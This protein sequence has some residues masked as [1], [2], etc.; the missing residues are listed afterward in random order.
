ML[1]LFVRAIPLTLLKKTTQ[2]RELTIRPAVYMV[3]VACIEF[4]LDV[5]SDCSSHFLAS[6]GTLRTDKALIPLACRV[7]RAPTVRAFDRLNSLFAPPS[8][9]PLYDIID[10][11]TGRSTRTLPSKVFRDLDQSFSHVPPRRVSRYDII[12]GKNRPT[13]S[14][15]PIQSVSW[16]GTE[17]QPARRRR[18]TTRRIRGGTARRRRLSSDF[19]WTGA[20]A[21][22][23]S[24]C[25]TWTSQGPNGG[26]GR[27]HL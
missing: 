22:C 6:F 3:R 23:I 26:E 24:M 1:A 2:M 10:G 16:S 17:T 20:R 25:M 19:R 27:T 21:G 11:K 18:Y 12:D 5:I 7:L 4:M 8:L 9:V 14:D 13:G 15:T